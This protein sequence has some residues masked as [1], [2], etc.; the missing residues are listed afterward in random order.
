MAK[1]CS[2]SWWIC[3]SLDCVSCPHSQK[4]ARR[5]LISKKKL[6][7]V[8]SGYGLVFFKITLKELFCWFSTVIIC[9]AQ[10]DPFL[11]T[12]I[13]ATPPK[14]I[15]TYLLSPSY[16]PTLFQTFCLISDAGSEQ[17]GQQKEKRE[18]VLKR[19]NFHKSPNPRRPLYMP[20]ERCFWE[21]LSKFPQTKG[22]KLAFIGDSLD[23]T[24]HKVNTLDQYTM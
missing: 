1:N 10:V 13:T 16:V 9:S 15:L 8:K 20:R 4:F 18:K 2:F 6:Y 22:T 14:F 19:V 3:S 17:T 12:Q 5:S 23:K 24:Y 21:N 7:T 11:M